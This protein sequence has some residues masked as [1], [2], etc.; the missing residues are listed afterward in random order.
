[1][2]KKLKVNDITLAGLILITGCL[3][4]VSQ[5]SA[6]NKEELNIPSNEGCTNSAI[7][8]SRCIIDTMLNDIEKTYR[9]HGGGGISSIKQI[10]TW[11]YTIS[12]S[13]EERVDLITYTVKL[14][15]KGKIVIMDRKIE[16]E[17]AKPRK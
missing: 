17:S 5:S 11:S 13:Q 6:S 8:Q 15:S 10:S 12:I 3:S 7:T 4:A 1:M 14:S 2:S 16:T 9:L